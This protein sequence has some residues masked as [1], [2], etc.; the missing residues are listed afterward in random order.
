MALL[1]CI[2]SLQG[3]WLWVEVVQPKQKIASL[4]PSLQAA[5]KECAQDRDY[6]RRVGAALR[7]LHG[8]ASDYLSRTFVISSGPCRQEELL[9]LELLSSNVS[10]ARVDLIKR[11]ADTGRF[12]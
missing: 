5:V 7:E 4:S 11:T 1:I 3:F 6:Q 8:R 10:Q 9:A 12:N 2:L